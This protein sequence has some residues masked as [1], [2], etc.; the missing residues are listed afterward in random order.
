MQ[1]NE[2]IKKCSV[3]IIPH[4]PYFVNKKIEF[5]LNYCIPSQN[6]KHQNPNLLSTKITKVE[7]FTSV[8]SDESQSKHSTIKMLHKLKLRSG[9][10]HETMPV[11]YILEIN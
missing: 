8:L 11:R 2:D 7:N 1:H 6:M 4:K 9:C 5:Q 10:R 3:E